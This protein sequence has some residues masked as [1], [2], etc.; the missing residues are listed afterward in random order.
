MKSD[1]LKGFALLAEFSDEDR[2]ALAGLLDAR[3]LVDGKSAFREG[4]E[5]DGL[6]LLAEGELKLTSRRDVD[7][8]GSLTAPYHLGVA[9]LFSV[10]KREVTAIAQG[11]CELWLLPRAGLSRLA[12]D[13]PRAAFRLAE[14]AAA[15]LTIFTR[16][17][18]DALLEGDS[19]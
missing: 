9:S 12:E 18:L 10:G 14:A 13:A 2:D 5:A 11:P 4:D 17:G 6:V 15:E 16:A 3:R 1:E 7:Q 19:S 8:L